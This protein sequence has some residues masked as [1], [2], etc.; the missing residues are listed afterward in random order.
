MSNATVPEYTDAEFLQA[1]RTQKIPLEQWSH[2]AHLRMAYL[3]IA[4]LINNNPNGVL[5]TLDACMDVISAGIK[6]FNAPYAAI[7]TVGYHTTMTQ[8]WVQIVLKRFQL[9]T[10]AA[11]FLQQHPE[12]M[13]S[14]L[15]LE[16][17]SRERMFSPEAKAAYIEPDLKP[18]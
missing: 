18:L 13:S 6:A 11:E 7:L 8:F 10:S 3:T 14:K 15:F 4:E 1:F 16:Y 2:Y 17:Y 12:L 5:P 9:R